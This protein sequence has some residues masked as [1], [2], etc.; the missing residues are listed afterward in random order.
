M[1]TAMATYLQ[2]CRNTVWTHIT[3]YHELAKTIERAHIGKCYTI[4]SANLDYYVV[5]RVVKPIF[6]AVANEFYRHPRIYGII[7]GTGMLL[8]ISYVFHENNKPATPPENAK[9]TT[10]PE[11]AEPTTPPIGDIPETPIQEE[12]PRSSSVP[13]KKAGPVV[14]MTTTATTTTTTTTGVR[15]SSQSE[16]LECL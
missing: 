8:L 13:V 7:A 3:S 2:T 6:S 9:L 5:E 11:N 12:R 15:T 1:V 16:E 10:P 4:V 14:T